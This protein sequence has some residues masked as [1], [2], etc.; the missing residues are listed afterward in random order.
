MASFESEKAADL[1]RHLHS[2]LPSDPAL[3]VKVLESLAVE[4]GLVAPETL[5]AWIEAYSDHIGP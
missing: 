3:R 5:D 2:D 1:H 4:R